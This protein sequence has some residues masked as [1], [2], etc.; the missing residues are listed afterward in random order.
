MEKELVM[1]EEK[2]QLKLIKVYSQFDRSQKD[3]SMVD[4]PDGASLLDIRNAHFP[5]DVEVVVSVNGKIIKN[6]ELSLTYL[7]DKDNILFIPE[8]TGASG[9][10]KNPLRMLLMIVVAVAAAYTGGAAAAAAGAYMSSTAAGVVGAFA[11]TAVTMIGGMLVNAF[12]PP[13]TG[14]IH[15]Y[16]SGPT[17]SWNPSTTQEQGLVIPRWYG[18][19]KVYGNVIAAHTVS[20]ALGSAQY[21]NVLLCLGLGPIKGI[22]DEKIND[23]DYDTYY[24]V[25]TYHRLG[26]MDQTYIDSFND[27][28]TQYNRYIRIKCN[29][30]WIAG[31]NY[32]LNDA[33]TYGNGRY[34]CIQAN[35]SSSE[36]APG[37]TD[38]WADMVQTTAGDSF[39]QLE[40]EL[41]FPNGVWWMDSKG[42][43]HTHGIAISVMISKVP[44]GEETEEWTCLTTRDVIGDPGF[45]WEPPGTGIGYWSCG[46]SRIDY[47]AIYYPETFIHPDA[48]IWYEASCHYSDGWESY[49]TPASQGSTCGNVVVSNYIPGEPMEYTMDTTWKWISE[50]DL[51]TVIAKGCDGD[52]PSQHEYP[53]CYST[54]YYASM[55][56]IKLSFR[57]ENL[58]HGQY[59]IRVSKFTEDYDDYQHYGD[60]VYLTSIKEIYQDDFSYPRLALSAIK[61]LATD[62]LSG[63]LK[64]SC[65][66]YGS[67]VCIPDENSYSGGGLYAGTIA[68]STNPAWVCWDILTQPV[69][70][71]APTYE[72]ASPGSGTSGTLAVIRFDGVNPSRLNYSDF[73]IW[74]DHCDELVIDKNG[75]MP[76]DGDDSYIPTKRSTFNGGFDSQITMWEA[77]LRVCNLARAMLIWNGTSLTVSIDKAQDSMQLF[78][79]GNI[80][81]G[82]FKET[83]VSISERA[84]EIECDFM[85]QDSDYNKDRFTVFN[86][87]AED[88]SGKYVISLD[89][90]G[91]IYPQEIWRYAM[92]RLYQNQ[93]LTKTI[94]FEADVDSIACTVGDVISVQHDTPD[95]LYG[96]RIVSAT[97]GT[98]TRQ[99][100]NCF[101]QFAYNG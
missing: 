66:V 72:K 24:G 68:Y 39:D 34:I 4:L 10:N 18:I 98:V 7:N 70:S 46:F 26:S 32:I 33:V 92:Y 55:K 44:E 50:E 53:D 1:T 95:W 16:D 15:D 2:P 13:D 75:V 58:V 25:E 91:I 100:G 73:K 99:A 65:L 87:D 93:Y 67:Y 38:Y 36:N 48:D 80:I 40:V 35:T 52:E 63:S 30:D 71:G 101:W 9:G 28:I 64:Y 31:K 6:E 49:E 12:L 14:P 19:N 76:D 37:N 43:V 11:A 74:A 97:S 51:S 5:L 29:T 94:E 21:L 81:K 77:A 62:Q 86:T 90:T 83:F 61:A 57:S 78:S 8:I 42:A 41:T 84:S 17:Y 54:V 60:L 96:G 85:N 22:D 3:I 79:V 47:Y 20:K 88:S 27:T 89:L 82:T 23:Q 56:S 45:I 69:Y 59:K